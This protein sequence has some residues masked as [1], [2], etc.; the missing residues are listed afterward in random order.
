MTKKAHTVED[1][2]M[3]AAANAATTQ[4]LGGL[5]MAGNIGVAGA[6]AANLPSPEQVQIDGLGIEILGLKAQ[7]THLTQRLEYLTNMFGWPHG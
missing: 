7:V 5:V 1:A 4:E 3:T 2:D 6:P